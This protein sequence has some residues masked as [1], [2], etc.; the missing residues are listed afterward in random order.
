MNIGNSKQRVHINYTE[1]LDLL[2]RQMFHLLRK[3]A[4]DRSCVEIE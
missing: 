1:I 2:P 4:W 3:L